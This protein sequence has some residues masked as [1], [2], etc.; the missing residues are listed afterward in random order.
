MLPLLQSLAMKQQRRHD[1]TLLIAAAL[2]SSEQMRKQDL[3]KL[4]MTSFPS[5]TSSFFSAHSLSSLLKPP[6]LPKSMIHP[7][8]P[9]PS[10]SQTLKA[11]GTSLRR[12][13]DSYVDCLALG[14][15]APT[16]LRQTKCKSFPDK[17]FR[18]VSD[19]ESQG[20]TEIASFLP[21]GRAFMVH[22]IDRFV[23]EIMPLYFKQSKWSSF[24]RQLNLWG[25]LRIINGPDAGGFYHCLFLKGRPDLVSYMARVGATTKDGT[26]RRR[27]KNVSYDRQAC[28]P[29]FYDMNVATTK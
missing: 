28:D 19:L 9:T 5:A 10:P 8:T 29:D 26:D 11:L 17:V 16:T 25:M 15:Q 20:L 22:D 1:E 4:Q 21:H 7:V 6:N 13:S 24:T 27:G 3:L 14:V 2:A 18:M 23:A 12:R